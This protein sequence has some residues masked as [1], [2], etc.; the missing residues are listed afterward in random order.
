MRTST[1]F[2]LYSTFS[3]N[4]KG[5]KMSQ[6]ETWF[7]WYWKTWPLIEVH[8]RILQSWSHWGTLYHLKPL[9][10]CDSLGEVS[11]VTK[12]IS[13]LLA[14]GK[15]RVV[16]GLCFPLTVFALGLKLPFFFHHY[17]SSVIWRES[18]KNIF[19]PLW[20][21]FWLASGLYFSSGWTRKGREAWRRTGARWGFQALRL[22]GGA[23]PSEK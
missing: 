10:F 14:P 7:S 12:C 19:S 23:S 20:Q 5:R 8:G 3:A 22:W 9:E 17:L 11:S 4:S 16:S 6:T 15:L 13:C 2:L 1:Q 18:F 21:L